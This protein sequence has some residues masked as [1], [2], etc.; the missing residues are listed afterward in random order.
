MN[1]YILKFCYYFDFGFWMVVFLLIF[2]CGF[3]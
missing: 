2:D 1:G 3:Y